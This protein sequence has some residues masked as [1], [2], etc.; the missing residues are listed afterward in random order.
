MEKDLQILKIERVHE[1]LRMELRGSDKESVKFI[2]HRIKDDPLLRDRD[3]L[4]KTLGLVSEGTKNLISFREC[5]S[6]I[7][8]GIPPGSSL[9]ASRDNFFPVPRP[10]S[11]LGFVVHVDD[12]S[13]LDLYFEEIKEQIVRRQLRTARIKDE[14]KIYDLSACV[15]GSIKYKG[16]DVSLRGQLTVLCRLFM[17]NHGKVVNIDDIKDEIFSSD[18]RLGIS[19][20]T[21]AKYVSELHKRLKEAFGHKVIFN[22]AKTG[23]KLELNKKF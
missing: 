1:I 19:N 8:A 20:Q 11:V 7:E 2:F 3:G 17:N 15:D 16:K 12:S 21:V 9:M 6:S 5:T 18:K 23:W 14:I 10:P 22:S 13:K 4:R